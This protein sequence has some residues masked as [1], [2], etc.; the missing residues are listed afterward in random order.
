MVAPFRLTV[1]HAADYEK[2][3][4]QMLRKLCSCRAL[5]DTV[6]VVYCKYTDRDNQSNNDGPRHVLNGRTVHRQDLMD[7]A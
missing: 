5:V 6:C 3:D 2:A 4:I 1:M 7:S